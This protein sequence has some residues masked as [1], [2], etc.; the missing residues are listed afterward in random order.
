MVVLSVLVDI[1][2]VL[3]LEGTEAVVLE[4][5]DVGVW[6]VVPD[7]VMLVDDE[8]VV[9]TMVV[10]VDDVVVLALVDTSVVLVGAVYSRTKVHCHVDY[11]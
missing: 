3:V 8:D 5:V 7:A 11:R 9:V 10:V 6:V 1:V 4:T 2:L